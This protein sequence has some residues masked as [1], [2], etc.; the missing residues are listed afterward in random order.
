MDVPHERHQPQGGVRKTSHPDGVDA[1]RLERP[2]VSLTLHQAIDA[3][4]DAGLLKG[5]GHIDKLLLRSSG[6]EGSGKE[7]EPQ[8]LSA[9]GVF[10]SLGSDPFHG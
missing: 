7:S 8:F 6:P 1:E 10:S 3:Q 9:Q 5:C 4:R 2:L